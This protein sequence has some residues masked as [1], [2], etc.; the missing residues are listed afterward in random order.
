M[1]KEIRCADVGMD[2]DFVTSADSEEELMQIVVQHAQDVHG[3]TEITPELQ[4]KVAEV[5][6]DV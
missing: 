3:I 5:I 1:A 6:R 2:C 4:A